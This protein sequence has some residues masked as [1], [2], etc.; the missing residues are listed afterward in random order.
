MPKCLYCNKDP[1]ICR[2][3]KPLR[4]KLSQAVNNIANNTNPN[5]TWQ[6]PL[7][8]SMTGTSS[9]SWSGTMTKGGATT[10]AKLADNSITALN[11]NWEKFNKNLE[12]LEEKVDKIEKDLADMRDIL[13]LIKRKI[14]YTEDAILKEE[15][16]KKDKKKNK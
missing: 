6:Q 8:K 11:P 13:I 3:F 1:C 10:N 2:S 15:P 16:K 7:P 14:V 12:R 5:P 9:G 4:K